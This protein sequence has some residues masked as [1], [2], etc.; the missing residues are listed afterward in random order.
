MHK[1]IH[2]STLKYSFFNWVIEDFYTQNLN[3]KIKIVPLNTEKN[4]TEVSLAYWIMD[5][6]AYSKINGT[7]ILCTDYFLRKMFYV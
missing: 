1:D 3:K 5:D 6:G 2:F 7:I 4:F